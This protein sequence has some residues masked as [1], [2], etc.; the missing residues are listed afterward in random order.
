MSQA[1]SAAKSGQCVFSQVV[2]G[3]V[4]KFKVLTQQENFKTCF[5]RMPCASEVGGEIHQKGAEA[6]V[7]SEEITV[8]NKWW[9]E[10]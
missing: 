2:G 3:L 7:N 6:C 9:S 8:D 10:T 5:K 4:G 1:K